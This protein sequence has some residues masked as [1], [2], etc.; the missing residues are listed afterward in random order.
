MTNESSGYLLDTSTLARTDADGRR[1][2]ALEPLFW[3]MNSAFGGWVAA[4]GVAATQHDARYRGEVITQNVQFHS[5]VRSEQL[6]VDVELVERRRTIDFWKVNIADAQTPTRILAAATLIA[7][8]RTPTKTG[9]EATH[10]PMR[11]QADCFSLQRTE[12]TPAWLDHFD[13]WLAKGRP[14]KKNPTP[15]SAIYVRES[16]GRPIDGKALVAIADT[17]MPRTFFTGDSR[18]FASTIALSTHIY[19]SDSELQASG[20]DFVLLD[21]RCQTIRHSLLNQETYVYR[22][23]GLLLAASYQTGLFREEIANEQT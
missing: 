6:L 4:I 10:E 8:E 3:N 12:Q 5:A 13:I 2:V 9:F 14:F 17:P 20:N 21:T 23:D 7:G 15:A 1:L 16:D 18:L 19:A 22:A 11:A